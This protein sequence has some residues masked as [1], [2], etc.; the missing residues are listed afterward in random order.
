MTTAGAGTDNTDFSTRMVLTE[1]RKEY[2]TA[3]ESVVAL[4]ST[5]LTIEP[6]EFVCVVGPSGCG[7]TTLLQ[8]LAGFE[9]P[10]DGTIMVGNTHI[11]GPDPD[12]GVVFQNSNLYPWLSV[13]KNVEFGLK[14]RGVPRAQRVAEADRMLELVGLELYGNRKPYELSGG[15]QQRCQIARVL[16]TD[17]RIILMDEPFGALDAMTRERLQLE[18]LELWR[19]RRKTVLFVTHSVEEAIFLGTRVIVMGARPG[20]VIY[21]RKVS[22][23]GDGRSTGTGIRST[24]DFISMRDE[25]AA[26][27]YEAQGLIGATVANH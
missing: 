18:L 27:I 11:K 22:F 9:A 5:N 19:E 23:K 15:Q 26:K 24:P 21:D 3:D 13:R 17:P 7:K 4:A 1:V 25:V 16:I 6:G 20:R 14:M 8:L 10:T 2:V 12:R